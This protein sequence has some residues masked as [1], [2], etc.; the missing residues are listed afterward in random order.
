MNTLSALSPY[1]FATRRSNSDFKIWRRREIDFFNRIGHKRPF[2]RITRSDKGNRQMMKCAKMI[3]IV[4][5]SRRSRGSEGRA[6]RSWF[7]LC[8]SILLTFPAFAGSEDFGSLRVQT[9]DKSA[10]ITLICSGR[11]VDARLD[12]ARF[13][14][15]ERQDDQKEHLVVTQ[16]FY[17]I[18]WFNGVPKILEKET[19][20]IESIEATDINGDGIPELLVRYGAGGHTNVLVIFAIK[21]CDIARLPGAEFGSDGGDTIVEPERVNSY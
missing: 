18:W 5:S 4:I 14:Y 6:T 17:L 12:A 21:N 20:Y 9:P 10:A 13:F 1:V 19:G 7:T 2:D 11:K 15:P 3:N 8:F 16:D